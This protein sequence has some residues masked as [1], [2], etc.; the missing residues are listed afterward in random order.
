V[1]VPLLSVEGL[2]LACNRDGAAVRLIDDVRFDIQPGETF[3]IVGESG[4]GKTM[5]ARAILGLLPPGITVADGAIRFAGNDLTQL[6]PHKMRSLR[7]REIGMIFQE[8]MTSL[9][10]SIPVGRQIGEALR[11]HEGL[12]VRAARARALEM[13]RAVRIADPE[14]AARSYPHQFSGGMRQRI[15]IA[16]VLAMR[17]KLLIADEP[18]TALDALI[19]HEVMDLMTG[20]ARDAGTAI[21]LISHDLGMVAEYAGR[22]L[23]MR[24]GLAIEAGTPAEILLAPRHDYTRSLLTSLPER[25]APAEKNPKPLVDVADLEVAYASR[26]PLFGRKGMPVRAVKGISLD[27]R[28][29]ETLAVVGE[30]GS[31]KTTLGRA[32]LGL[33]AGS[34]GTISFEGKPLDLAGCARS[35]DFRHKTTMI[36]QDPGGSLDPRM[37]LRDIVAEPLRGAVRAS[38]RAAR[39]VQAL[40][41]VGLGGDYG[42]RFPHEL[43]GG[44]RQRVAI[45]RAI[46][47][48]PDLVVA[49]EPVSA[50]DPSVQHQVLALFADLQKEHGF[51]SLFVTHDL[52]VVEQVAD[53]VA[54]MYHGNLVE[55]GPRDAI[56]DRPRHPY[57]IRLLE[58]APRIARVDGGGFELTRVTAKAAAPPDRFDWFE[59]GDTSEMIEVASGHFVA[60]VHRAHAA[61]TEDMT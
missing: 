9:N 40:E 48:R 37:R 45:A 34:N 59:D 16:S 32:I 14:R 5:I 44:Q 31:G 42:A 36:F 11:L 52:A 46:I 28:C 29:G 21:L 4:S 3:A 33:C 25:A 30:S 60:C 13:L 6:A 54:V 57:T 43:S 22:L 20:L 58:A 19:R 49:D 23:V 1:T 50:L 56:F 39:A 27:V 17:P 7:G 55:I 8:P 18:T 26:A 51:A 38:E 12:S 24:R 53:R 61:Q 47:A 41:E 15:M 2:S 35:R 10:P